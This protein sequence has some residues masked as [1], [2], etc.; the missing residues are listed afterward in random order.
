[1]TPRASDTLASPASSRS[2]AGRGLELDAWG[3]LFCGGA[4]RRMGRDK[5]RLELGGEALI[6]RAAR[7]LGEVAP[8]VL[9]ASGAAP[10]YPELGLE[11]VLDGGPEVGPLGGLA[12]VLARLEAEGVG[13]ACALAC[14]MPFVDADVFRA[15]LGRARESG[16]EVVLLETGEGLEPL[17]GIYHRR[18]LG[19]VRAAL[20][21][22]ER[23]MISFH[24]DVRVV[25]VPARTFGERRAHNLNTREDFLAAGGRWT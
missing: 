13:H 7:V 21:R 10:R 2:P 6:A 24:A 12:A 19:A 16:A 18:A 11:C 9:L 1:M 8:R 23:R 5:A 20:A 17:C 3:A 25:A 14:D 4:S 22:G 15:L